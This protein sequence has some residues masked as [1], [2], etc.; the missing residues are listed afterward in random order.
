MHLAAAVH[1]SLPWS[2]HRSSCRT[3]DRTESQLLLWQEKS[4]WITFPCTQNRVGK[5]PTYPAV[6]STKEERSSSNKRGRAHKIMRETSEIVVD[7]CLPHYLEPTK[8]DRWVK[9]DVKRRGARCQKS[10]PPPMIVFTAELEV[11]Q[12]NSNLCTG[13]DQD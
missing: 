11:A 2:I 1:F 4:L 10:S 3:T 13:N 9:K 6:L 8:V 7:L 12:N 5:W